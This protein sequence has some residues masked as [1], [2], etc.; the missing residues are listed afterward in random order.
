[1][2]RA[3][4]TFFNNLTTEI[5]MSETK[6]VG[7]KVVIESLEDINEYIAQNF[8]DGLEAKL[9]TNWPEESIFFDGGIFR[10]FNLS[11]Y[12]YSDLLAAECHAM[13]DKLK[14]KIGY[15][16]GSPFDPYVKTHKEEN[17]EEWY[18][19]YTQ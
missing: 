16:Y 8:P 11:R 7:D 18:E 15:S 1:M 17:G 3:S 5:H 19:V 9:K 14:G 4:P 6:H 10:G 12:A 2:G 13:R